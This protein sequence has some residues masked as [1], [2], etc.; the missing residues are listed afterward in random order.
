MGV[1]C[2]IHA[3][4]PAHRHLMAASRNSN[5]YEMALVGPNC[6]NA[7][8]PVYQCGYE[9]QLNAVDPQGFVNVPAGPGLGVVYDWAYINAH[10]TAEFIYS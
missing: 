6:S 3:C 5:F 8:A 7:V 2:E 10:K 9:D 1:D 4:G